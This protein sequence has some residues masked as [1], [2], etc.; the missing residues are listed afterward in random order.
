MEPRKK[1]MAHRYFTSILRDVTM[2]KVMNAIEDTKAFKNALKKIQSREEN[3]Y[4][5]AEKLTQK[6]INL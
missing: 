4:Q 2:D 3:P 6:I 5:A 1:E